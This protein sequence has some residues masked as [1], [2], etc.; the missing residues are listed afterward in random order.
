VLVN[1]IPLTAAYGGDRGV[2]WGGWPVENI[3]RIEVICGPGSALY[4]ADA[5]SGVIN[6]IT[7][8]AAD[9]NGTQVGLRVGSYN[10]R[11]A[12]LLHGGS[13]GPVTVAAYL[14]ASRTDGSRP[15]I[16]ADAQTGLDQIFAPFGVAPVSRAPGPADNGHDMFD[17]KLDLGYGKWRLRAAYLTR[18]IGSGAGAALALDPTGTS[19]GQRATSDL[20]Y[21]DPAFARD[22]ALTLQASAMHYVEHSELVL[23]PAGSNLG[24]GF[25]ADGVI[26]NPSK[27]ERH[28]RLSASTVYAGFPAHRVRLG[29]GY[30]AESLYK[31]QET[32]NFNPDFSPIGA[33]SVDDVVD[34]TDTVPF[35]RP[36][37]RRVRYAY[38]QDEWSFANDWTLTA[39]LRQD[40]YSDFGRTTNPRVALVWD[41]AYNVTAKLLYGSAFRAPSFLELY[42]INNPALIGNPGL[43][44]ETIKTLEGVVSWKAS[45]ALQWDLDVFR[46]AMSDIIR[47]D[48][49]LTYQNGGRQTGNGLELETTWDAMSNLRL[50][51]QF[52]LQHS[53]DEATHSDAGMAAHHLARIRGDWTF[54]PGWLTSAQFNAV[55]SRAR[56]SGDPRAPLAGYQTFDL[57]LVR[58]GDHAAWEFSATVR[59]LFAA[60]QREPSPF[61]TPYIALPGDL[62]IGGRSFSLEARHRF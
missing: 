39:G 60:D 55:G 36:H 44:P 6:I 4:G 25:F 45:P 15:T 18:R 26:G 23:F 29:A 30:E 12:W 62:P 10:A 11:A 20:S 38:V 21:Q 24:K 27:Y 3:A 8:T 41:A 43:K 59:N 32:K 57:S 2:N 46:Y 37:A 54:Q 13:I 14:S 40:R 61:G 56:A 42:L 9:V 47:V 5:F 49:S 48:S 35:M 1:G 19:T 17:S 34:V 7:K 31:I 33:G 53:T 50:Y 58:R 51:G 22:W 28:G 52:S 16:G